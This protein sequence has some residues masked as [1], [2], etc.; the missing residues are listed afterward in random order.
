MVSG[1][2]NDNWLARINGI[3]LYGALLEAGIVVY[4]Y[5][6]SML[7]HKVMVVDGVWMTIGTTNFDTRSFAHNEE[8]NL[9]V[10]DAGI[11]NAFEEHFAADLGAC[12]EVT[13]E[14]WRRRGWLQRTSELVARFFEDQV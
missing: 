4:E 2:R 10:F 1:I 7:H 8:S 11:A 9:S 3:A 13:L 6:R 14:A 12:R 5:D